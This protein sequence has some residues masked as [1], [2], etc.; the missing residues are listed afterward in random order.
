MRTF[1]LLSL[2]FVGLAS[3]ASATAEDDKDKSPPPDADK[4]AQHRFFE[5]DVFPL[6]KKR[7]FKCH[8]A[9]KK[10]RGNLRLDHRAGILKGG[11]TGPAVNLKQPEKSLLLEAINY[12]SYEM[13][14]TGKLP[15]QERA[16][17]T[18]WVKLGVPWSPKIKVTAKKSSAETQQH[19]PPVNE[20]TK[21]FWSFQPVKRPAV[22]KVR[23]TD[24]VRNPIDAFILAKLEAQ[25]L[26]PAPP[27]MKTALLRRA[28]YDLIGLPPSPEEVRAFLADDSPHAFEKVVDRLLKSPHYGEKWGRHWLDLVRYAETNSY[29]RDNAKPHVWRY[30][31]YVIR[32]FNR[33]KP[34]TQFIKEQ[35]AGDE[36]DNVT[37]E[38]IIATGYYRLG[39][40]DDEPAD[41]KRALYDDLDD[42]LLTT[43]QVFLGLT[44][45]CARCHNHKISPIPQQDYYRFLAFFNGLNRYGI[46][47]PKSIRRFSVR[48]IGT[49]EQKRK[50][51]AAVKAHQ[52]KV[53]KNKRRIAAIEKRVRGVLTNV[54]KED[55]QYD[56]NRVALFKKHVSQDLP[57]Q[58]L[59]EYLALRKQREKL[60]KFSP[61]AL[62]KALCVTEIGPK[63]RKTHVLIRGNPHVEGP[64]VQPGFPQVLS[65]PEPV[66]RP[67]Q[68]GQKTSNRRRAL[69]EW[70][71]SK[72]NPL[73]ARVMANRIWQYHFGRGLVRSPNNFGFGGEKPTHPELLDW[74]AAEFMDGGWKMKRLHK[75]IMLS[76]TYRMSSRRS[77]QAV[78]KDPEN[79]LFWRFNVRRL[80]AEE[81]RD[82][83]LAVNGALNRDKMFGPSIFT[84]M[85]QAVLAGQS[86]PGSGWGKSSPEE[87]NRRSIYIH[88]KRSL[89][90]PILVAFDAADPDSTCPVRFSTTQP[91]Q[92]L[93]MLNSDFIHREA[94]VFAEHLEQTAGN[95]PREQVE[96]ALWRVFQRPPTK[97]E[98]ERGLRLIQSLKTD[99]NLSD[100]AALKMFCLV[101]LNLNEFLFVD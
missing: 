54:E 97:Q 56:K 67:P 4:Q 70:I 29:E 63:P 20:K 49:E 18:K 80:T 74:L 88:I 47:S 69:A 61:P 17:L 31:D 60:K 85:P 99:H 83:I 57:Q 39:I 35:L 40:W 38:S 90:P 64:E 86:R 81:I 37:R 75:M 95:T 66:V 36:L 76:N 23:Q 52:R 58:L 24:W 55:F 8:S 65:P 101:A 51:A 19:E 53:D 42:I 34:Y 44:M 73:T 84:I 87:R 30:R 16:V 5:N 45:N 11:D 14:P 10:I 94:T 59:D 26:K 21:Q 62:D 2:L 22:P 1:S 48:S 43:S 93:G 79:D 92:A 6:L 91:T 68:K 28:Y 25:G 82:S 7:C 15:A 9:G 100:R 50:H 89:R 3:L 32:S 96:T 41:P 27:A 71:A 77:E 98:I 13:P 46:R 78:A 33:D 12:E 72:D